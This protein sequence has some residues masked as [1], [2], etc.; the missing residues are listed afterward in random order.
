MISVD[1]GLQD[2][3]HL[4][5]LVW[6]VEPAVL[7]VQQGCQVD[8]GVVAEQFLA[9]EVEI[10]EHAAE[11]REAH[12]PV[13]LVHRDAGDADVVPCMLHHVCEVLEVGDAEVL[14]IW[15]VHW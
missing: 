3:A 7:V 14:F 2:A 10:V 11:G 6:R 9:A 15:L 5:V 12:V 1:V 8:V 13:V 4:E